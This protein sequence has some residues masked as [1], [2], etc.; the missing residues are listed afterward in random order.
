MNSDNTRLH[1]AAIRDIGNKREGRQRHLSP[2]RYLPDDA[3]T[4][5]PLNG[6]RKYIERGHDTEKDTNF[7]KLHFRNEH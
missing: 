4:R 7:Y 2:S 1:D 3:G 6:Q 5:A